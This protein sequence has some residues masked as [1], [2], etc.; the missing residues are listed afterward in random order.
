M[1]KKF[2]LQNKYYGE[3]FKMFSCE[4]I[5]LENG[6]TVL[7]GCNGAGKTT[8]MRQI[9]NQL[10]KEKIPV[11]YHDFLT[12]SIREF[13]QSAL[14]NENIEFLALSVSSSEGENIQLVLGEVAREMGTLIRRSNPDAKEYWFLFDALDSGLSIDGINEIKKN[15]FSMVIDKER[16]KDI[17]II[18][19]TNSY[20]FAREESCFDVSGGK[21]ITFKDYGDY[22]NFIIKSRQNKD[23]RYG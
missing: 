4:N 15:L 21:Y 3:N 22:R 13:R 9:E 23:K 8:F 14:D 17:Y 2:K 6:L 19:S 5:E 12:H 11:I 18:V 10:K 20:E 16:N 1:S 7:V